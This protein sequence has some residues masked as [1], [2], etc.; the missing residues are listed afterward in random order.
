MVA[1]AFNPSTLEAEA[2][3]SEFRDSLVYRVSSW[4]VRAAVLKLCLKNKNQ[5]RFQDRMTE[6]SC[7]WAS[8]H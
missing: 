7:G 3:G 6:E 4:T 5:K 8:G 1:C 2:A